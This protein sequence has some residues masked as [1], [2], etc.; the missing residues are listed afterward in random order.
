MG[1]RSPDQSTIGISGGSPESHILNTSS[2]RHQSTSNCQPPYHF[3]GRTTQPFISQLVASYLLTYQMAAI[4]YSNLLTAEPERHHTL[5]GLAMTVRS[6]ADEY[7]NC[8]PYQ[9]HLNPWL[10]SQLGR[11]PKQDARQAHLPP[12]K[13]TPA[14]FSVVLNED[15]LYTLSN[16]LIH[17]QNVL[18]QATLYKNFLISGDLWIQNAYEDCEDCDVEQRTLEHVYGNAAADSEERTPK[19]QARRIERQ[20][21]VFNRVRILVEEADLFEAP[22]KPLEGH[23]EPKGVLYVTLVILAILANAWG[24]TVENL[25]GRLKSGESMLRLS[26]A[27][28]I[29]TVDSSP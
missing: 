25:I 20:R 28:W 8:K 9:I 16:N 11:L 2:A 18:K 27:E 24:G 1:S 6:A 7:L 17:R 21:G 29:L 15:E 12:D 4:S 5:G 26:D 3:L 23:R 13:R 19:V 10:D 22:F 14:R